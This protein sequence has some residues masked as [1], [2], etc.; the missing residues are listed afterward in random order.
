M[1]GT[2]GLVVT[3]DSI[4]HLMLMKGRGVHQAL[5]CL[6]ARATQLGMLVALPSWAHTCR[7]GAAADVHRGAQRPESA[8]KQRKG[9]EGTCAITKPKRDGRSEVGLAFV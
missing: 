7:P 4:V 1:Q 8:M 9:R 6:Q 5:A 2:L 3:L